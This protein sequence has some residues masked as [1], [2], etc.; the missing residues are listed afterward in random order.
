MRPHFPEPKG[1]NPEMCMVP[2]RA[3]GKRAHFRILLNLQNNTRFQL[4]LDKLEIGNQFNFIAYH[5]IT[6]FCHGAPV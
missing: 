4:L 2:L 5:D 1:E 3:R 6:S